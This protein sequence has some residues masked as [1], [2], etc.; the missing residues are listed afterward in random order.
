MILAIEAMR[1]HIADPLDLEQLARLSGVSTR[2]I[3]RLFKEKLSTTTM[4]FYRQLRLQTAEKLLQQ[5]SM[6]IIDIAQATGFVNAAHF[7]SA[8]NKQFAETPSSLRK[9]KALSIF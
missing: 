7:S 4:D 1:N 3:N 5:T 8:F 9:K 2:Q 6:K